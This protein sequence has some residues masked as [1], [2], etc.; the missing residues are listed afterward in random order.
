MESAGLNVEEKPKPGNVSVESDLSESASIKLN[1]KESKSNDE[2][3]KH[4]N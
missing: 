2:T 3:V 1:V 4:N